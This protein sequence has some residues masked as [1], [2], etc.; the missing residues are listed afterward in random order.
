MSGAIAWARESSSWE[1]RA[2]M[3][4]CCALKRATSSLSASESPSACTSHIQPIPRTE[5]V[6]NQSLAVPAATAHSLPRKLSADECEYV[7]SVGR[8][9]LR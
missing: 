6:F 3:A 1:M 2:L 5:K 4:L 9:L 8:S 7:T